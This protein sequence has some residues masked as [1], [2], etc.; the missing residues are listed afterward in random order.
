M[1]GVIILALLLNHNIISTRSHYNPLDKIVTNNLPLKKRARDFWKYNHHMLLHFD[2]QYT[3][4]SKY[5]REIVL[6]YN[7]KVITVGDQTPNKT[8]SLMELRGFPE[9][10]YRGNYD[11]EGKIKK[12]I[13]LGATCIAINSNDDAGDITKSFLGKKLGQFNDI[14]I[15]SIK[16]E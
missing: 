4:I 13:E 2:N 15:Y 8:L 16:K 12:M 5:L 9:Y 7:D 3:G 6:T 14:S 11:E 1:V 10:H